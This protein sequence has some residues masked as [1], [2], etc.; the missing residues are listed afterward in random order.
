MAKTRPLSLTITPVAETDLAEIW[1]Y[2]AED[3]AKAAT[4]FVEQKR[5]PS[6]TAL[7]SRGEALMLACTRD[8]MA[9]GLFSTE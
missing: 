3:S 1:A 4:A 5:Q 8:E 7:P 9:T 6:R 2:I